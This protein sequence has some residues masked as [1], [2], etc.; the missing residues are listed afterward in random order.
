MKVIFQ[1]AIHVIAKV[2]HLVDTIYGV[3][4]NCD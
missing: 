4:T 1:F 2:M 3:I